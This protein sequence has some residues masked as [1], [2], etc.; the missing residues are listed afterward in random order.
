MELAEHTCFHRDTVFITDKG[1]C[2]FADFK[3]GD[4][5]T[6]LDR[7]GNYREATVHY[8]GIKPMQTVIFAAGHGRTTSPIVCT[9]D[10]NWILEDGKVTC[11]I[12]PG[13]KIYQL[14]N[15]RDRDGFQWE[16]VDIRPYDDDNMQD[17]WCV[18]EPVTRS[19]TLAGGLVT[20]NCN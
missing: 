11:N 13:D 19:F 12:K 10:H 1:F 20:H 6:I 4:K 9:K 8:Y 2:T 14:P 18:E 5:V 16:V 15:N 7:E 17:C 3:N